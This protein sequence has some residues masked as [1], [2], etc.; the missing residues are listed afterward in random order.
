MPVFLLNLAC[1]INGF[2]GLHVKDDQMYTLRVTCS[3]CNEEHKK[4]ITLDPTEEYDVPDT[5]SSANVVIKCKFCG[6]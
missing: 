5:K 6:Q 3:G 1:D 4:S 2:K